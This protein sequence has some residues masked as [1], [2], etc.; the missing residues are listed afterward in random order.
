MNKQK[1]PELPKPHLGND[2]YALAPLQPWC[3]DGKAYAAE[4]ADPELAGWRV[5]IEPAGAPWTN[6]YMT[7]TDPFGREAQECC[8]EET[9]AE[10]KRHAAIRLND[11]VRDQGAFEWEPDDDEDE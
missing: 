10:R 8:D 1:K 7:I 9:L 6:H 3:K 4:H 2:P 11:A 5:R